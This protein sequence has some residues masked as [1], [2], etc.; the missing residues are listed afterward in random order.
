MGSTGKCRFCGTTLSSDERSCPH[1][2]APNELFV[3]NTPRNVF[4]P[5]T[6]DELKEYCAERG[7]PLLRMRF[8]IGQDY[9]QP[10]A[11]GIYQ[12]G[13]RFV[14]Y[15]NKANGERAIRY[16]GPDEEYAVRELLL[17][18][19]DEC[20]NRNIYPD[21]KPDD[22]MAVKPKTKTKRNS[23]LLP[24]VIFLTCVLLS[25]IIAGLTKQNH[26][27][28]GY[29]R[30]SED[31]LYYRYGSKWFYNNT[32]DSN[33]TE[34]EDVPADAVDQYY[35]GESF[36]TDWGKSDFK[37]S[38]AWAKIKEKNTSSSSDYERWDSEDTDW[39]SDW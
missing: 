19:L 26:K 23:V 13:S 27:S 8:F 3:V 2:G 20:H 24:V 17:K 29:Y 11:F 21:G 28:D 14:V 36:E 18:L 39:D 12:D 30:F 34:T 25:M 6:I 32:S 16:D 10:K 31:A 5:K 33:W 9:R 15:K 38:E 37:Q 1:C 35:V 4:L 7:M 22:T